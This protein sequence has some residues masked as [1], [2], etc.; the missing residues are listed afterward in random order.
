M[1]LPELGG[2]GP[3]AIPSPRT[4]E[5]PESWGD[6]TT[7]QGVNMASMVDPRTG[8]GRRNLAGAAG[9]A[10]A[11]GALVATAPVSL[12]VMGLAAGTAG[13]IGAMG[14]GLFE[15]L[16]EQVVGTA[17]PS[18][19][20]AFKAGAQQGA[21][22]LGGQAFVWPVKYAGRHLVAS[23]VSEAARTALA[24]ARKT[25]V[26]RLAGAVE[27]VSD[28]AQRDKWAV[29]DALKAAGATAEAGV[30][31]AEKQATQRTAAAAAPFESLVA[32]EPSASLAGQR[33][34]A[35]YARPRRGVPIGPAE[36]ARRIAGER[37]EQAAREAPDTDITGAK[38][39]AR[40]AADESD[41]V[42]PVYI[43]LVKLARD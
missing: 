20:A 17:P 23:S 13:V 18:T 25:R 42:T 9:A 31:T 11:T 43:D 21:Y 29:A 2:I 39:R 4:F 33:A 7:R 28:T 40:A 1:P 6:W 3:K 37:V 12:P 14:G 41:R 26:E 24:G 30:E 19:L 16:G 34:A 36:E 8:E 35:I 15:E 38:V 27:V 22:E 10:L 5:Q 32:Q